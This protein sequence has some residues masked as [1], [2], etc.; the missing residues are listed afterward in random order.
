MKKADDVVKSG[1]YTIIMNDPNAVRYLDTG[2]DITEGVIKELDKSRSKD[3]R[4]GA[5]ELSAF[6]FPVAFRFPLR[7]S[8]RACGAA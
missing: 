4:L 5:G 6:R 8:L 3:Q 7:R 2:V 1:K